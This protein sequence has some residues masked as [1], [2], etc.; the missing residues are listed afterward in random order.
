MLA[1]QAA[2]GLACLALQHE[3]DNR[4]RF[5]AAAATAAPTQGSA[6]GGAGGGGD[7]SG[8]GQ[9]QGRPGTATAA[10]AAAREAAALRHRLSSTLPSALQQPNGQFGLAAAVSPGPGLLLYRGPPPGPAS[11]AQAKSGKVPAQ[12]QQQKVHAGFAL[13]LREALGRAVSWLGWPYTGQ[14]LLRS[15][16]ALFTRSEALGGPMVPKWGCCQLQ[17][18]TRHGFGGST[19]HRERWEARGRL[20]IHNPGTCAQMHGS[21]IASAHHSCLV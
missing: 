12:Q 13:R 10:A 9:G 20:D 21:V 6:G 11:S 3:H 16:Q 17:R 2:E 7:A 8:A 15:W 14:L 19:G 4:R 1:L 5:L 18:Q